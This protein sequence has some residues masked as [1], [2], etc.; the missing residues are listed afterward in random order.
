MAFYSDHEVS[1]ADDNV[2]RGFG[3]AWFSPA[4]SS[5]LFQRRHEFRCHNTDSGIFVLNGRGYVEGNLQYFS[6]E[7]TDRERPGCADV[8]SETSFRCTSPRAPTAQP[9]CSG[10]TCR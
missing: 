4:A 1:P 7:E 6:G 2:S 10:G 8:E 3:R 9:I 5:G